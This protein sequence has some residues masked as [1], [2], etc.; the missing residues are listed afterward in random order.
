M[1][2]TEERH[3][4]DAEI[5]DEAEFYNH[6]MHVATYRFALRYVKGKSVLDWGCGTGYGSHMLAGIADKVTAVDIS[7]EAT[8]YAKETFAADNLA[9]GKIS[10]LSDQKFDVITAFQVIEHVRD[11]KKL[12]REMRTFLNPDGY[13]LISTPDRTN[14]LFRCIQR[15]WN[16]Y[17][18]KEYSG[19][20]LN[21]LLGEFFTRVEIQK[22]GSASEIVKKEILRTKRQR[23]IS[24]LCTLIFYPDYLRIFLLKLQK[25]IYE[26]ISR[27]RRKR[28]SYAPRDFRAK[29]SVTDIEINYNV[30]L[31]T[32]LLAICFI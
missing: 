28:K 7:D 29:Y 24:L 3:F 12:I 6:L 10:E 8:G 26:I 18:Y 22:I 23:L 19:I 20:S 21:N 2:K 17:H 1:N 16:I 11:G 5:T 4:S 15:P 9:F 30:T 14:R 31:S 13:L 27:L 25:R 32:D